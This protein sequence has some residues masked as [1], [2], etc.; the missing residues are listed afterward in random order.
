MESTKLLFCY[1]RIAPWPEALTVYFKLPEKQSDS[2]TF[3]RDERV[4]TEEQGSRAKQ[5]FCSNENAWEFRDRKRKK[6][7]IQHI[8]CLYEMLISLPEQHLSALVFGSDRNN[9]AYNR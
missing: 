8:L 1:Q 2:V 4:I 7:Y 9:K 5:K 6:V 3:F